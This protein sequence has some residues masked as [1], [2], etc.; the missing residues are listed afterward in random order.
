MKLS[1]SEIASFFSMFAVLIT[2]ITLVVENRRARVS[3]QTDL[4]LRLEDKLHSAEYRAIRRKAAAK[5]LKNRKPNLELEAVLELL[6]TIV[7]FCERKAIDGDWAYQ[8]FGYWIDRYWLCARQYVEE[9]SRRYD[10][11]S[12]RTLERVAT[13]FISKER[14]DGYSPYSEE[15]LN[16]FL[17]EEKGLPE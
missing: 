6:S 1:L 13:G 3:L 8:Q 12:Y 15:A 17:C 2:L 14:K 11:H 5:L 4:Q 9:E 16:A 7:Y 10:P